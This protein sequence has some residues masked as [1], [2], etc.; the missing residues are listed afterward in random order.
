MRLMSPRRTFQSCGNSSSEV[1]RTKR[2]TLVRQQIAVG[3]ALVSHGLEL[4]DLEYLA[5]LSWALLREESSCALVGEVQPQR[6][7]S[8]WQR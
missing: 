3:V 8:Q 5:T 2:P 6:Y 4:H 1:E 7:D